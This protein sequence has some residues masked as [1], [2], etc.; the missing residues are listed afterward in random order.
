MVDVNTQGVNDA[1]NRLSESGLNGVD[2]DGN[3]VVSAND[4]NTLLMAFLF[5]KGS[6]KDKE[7][8]RTTG[9]LKDN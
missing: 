6:A 3:C 8:S 4:L 2:D 7:T 9:S 5:A 1:F